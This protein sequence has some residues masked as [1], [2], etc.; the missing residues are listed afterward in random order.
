MNRSQ[1]SH[2]VEFGPYAELKCKWLH[3]NLFFKWIFPWFRIHFIAISI[4]FDIIEKSKHFFHLLFYRF[5]YS[6]LSLFLLLFLIVLLLVLFFLHEHFFFSF[7]IFSVQVVLVES[8]CVPLSM[9]LYLAH[10]LIAIFRKTFWQKSVF[11]VDFDL[12]ECVTLFRL[13]PWNRFFF[14]LC[15]LC[16]LCFVQICFFH[17]FYVFLMQMH[18]IHWEWIIYVWL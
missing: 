15:L 13:R 12:S 4:G 6:I 14:V 18:S 8:V 9:S 17:S 7:L 2:G 3:F 16:L 10:T 11:H 1:L 5:S